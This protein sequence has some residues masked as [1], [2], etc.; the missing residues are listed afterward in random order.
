LKKEK[1]C[2]FKQNSL[3]STMGS[4]IVEGPVRSTRERD[5]F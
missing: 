2:Q 4:Q 3:V 1:A 5:W